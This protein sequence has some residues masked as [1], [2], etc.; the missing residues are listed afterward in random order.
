MNTLPFAITE[1]IRNAYQEHNDYTNLGSNFLVKIDPEGQNEMMLLEAI[2]TAIHKA[3]QDHFGDDEDAEYDFYDKFN[4][5]NPSGGEWYDI[6]KE[7]A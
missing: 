4:I 5:D 2:Q 7:E 6:I 3:A 1:E